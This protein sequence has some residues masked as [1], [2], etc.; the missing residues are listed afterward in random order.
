M[1]LFVSIRESIYLI[2]LLN[3]IIYN[4]I[5]LFICMKHFNITVSGKVQGVFYRQSTLEVAKS[6]W[7]KGSVRN[8][9]DGNVY[10]EAEGEADQLAK[11]IE[12]CKTGPPRAKVAQVQFSEGEFKGFSSFSISR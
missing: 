1:G 4:A 3:S 11:L 9:P 7:L 8:E 2:I 5:T 6:L 10:I 12:W